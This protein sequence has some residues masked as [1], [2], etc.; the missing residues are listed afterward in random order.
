LRL[1]SKDLDLVMKAARMS[2]AEL[3][4]ASVAQSIL[5]SNVASSG[6]LDSFRSPQRSKSL[7]PPIRD[8]IRAEHEKGNAALTATRMIQAIA[9]PHSIDD[10]E[11]HIGSSIGISVYPDDGLDGET[12]IKNADTAMYHAKEHGRQRYE[13]FRPAM[14]VRAV[15]RQ[16]TEE[17]LRRALARQEFVLHFQPKIDLRTGAITGAEAFLRWAHPS[18]GMVA[19]GEFI[20]VAEDCGLILPIGNWVLREACR[21]ARAWLDAGLPLNSMAVNISAVEFRDSRFGECVLEIL[22]QTGLHPGHLQIEL[23]E[24]VLMKSAECTESIL[25]TLRARGVQVAI[26]D[27]GT[28]YSSLSYLTRFPID[29]LKIDQSFVHQITSAGSDTTVVTAIIGMGRNLDMRVVAEGVETREQA[30]FLRLH[31]CDEAQGYY[32]SRPVVAE[33]FAELLKTGIA[34]KVATELS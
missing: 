30:A 21:Q 5:A 15:A 31:R 7:G 20:P 9:A 16:S 25:N 8:S 22:D 28:G 11:L 34:R 14:N 13:F 18:R 32:F 24:G 12:L 33:Q 26:D 29:A 6:E 4:A 19:P 23:T 27:F 10:H 3:P 2:G 1:V 17:S